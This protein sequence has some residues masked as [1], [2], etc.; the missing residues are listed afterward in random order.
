LGLDVRNIYHDQLQCRRFSRTSAQILNTK[1][2][3]SYLRH[4]PIS[5]FESIITY[6]LYKLDCDHATS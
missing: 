6:L 4:Y 2:P 1:I 3:K 5:L